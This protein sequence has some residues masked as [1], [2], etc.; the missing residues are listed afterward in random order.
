[1]ELFLP[2]DILKW[3]DL[4]SGEK[5][6][7]ELH[8][9]LVE[10]NIPPLPKDYKDEKITFKGYRDF[11]FVDFPIR[12]KKTTLTLRRR[13]W[14]IEGRPTRLKRDI[15]LVAPGTTLEKEFADFLKDRG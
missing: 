2:S 15:T 3:F 7:N 13:T 6:N 14:K 4:I 5:T 12:G 1:M 8:L 10:K 11:T 9:T